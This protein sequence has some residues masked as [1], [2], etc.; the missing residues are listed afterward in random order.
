MLKSLIERPAVLVSELGLMLLGLVLSMIGITSFASAFTA[1]RLAFAGAFT[2]LL[3]SA[4]CI[5]VSL[6]T[7]LGHPRSTVGRVSLMVGG[8]LGAAYPLSLAFTYFGNAYIVA[9]PVSIAGMAL[10]L[11]S[12]GNKTTSG[13]KV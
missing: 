2:F 7:L 10:A 6:I 3:A 12:L 11:T 4:W 13:A 1:D 9:L 5:S 8:W